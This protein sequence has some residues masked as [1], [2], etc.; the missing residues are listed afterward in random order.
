MCGIFGI[1]GCE[2]VY[3]ELIY[4]LTTLQHRG[5][6]A[7]GIVTLDHTFNVKKG[8]GLIN[9]VFCD[10]NAD[11]LKGNVGLGHIRY[12]TKGS[13]DLVDAQPF[14]VNYPFGLA[15]VHNGNVTNFENL[16]HS[17]AKKHHR[18]LSSTNDVELILDILGL[19]LEKRNLNDLS[20][21]D[22]FSS[23]EAIQRKVKGAYATISIIAEHGM[24]AF[25]DPS[26]IRPLIF[27]KKESSAGISYAFASE[28]TCLD[29]LGYDALHN[30]QPGEAMYIDK[31]KKIHSKIC[32]QKDLAFC[33]FEYIYFAKEDSVIRGRLVAS[34]RERMG[35][36]LARKFREKGLYPDVVI[37]VPSAAYFCAQGLADALGVPYKRGLVKN[38][39]TKRSFISPTKKLRETIVSRKLNPI[40]S[41]IHGKSVAVVDDSI[42]RGTTSKYIIRQLRNFGAKEI[43]FASASPPLKHPCIYGI[44]MSRRDEMIASKKSEEEIRL[45]IEADALIYPTVEDFRKLYKGE[46]FCDACFSSDYPTEVSEKVFYSIEKE[47]LL[48]CR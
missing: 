45:F 14:T 10:G 2:D 26:A 17:L 31:E 25:M 27:G 47:K 6:D 38:N 37:D 28:S 36:A 44:D 11:K 18:M 13:T 30:L 24:L 33:I 9:D 39:N 40:K 41:H 5:Q 32:F 1:V 19:E 23:V 12:S 46:K 21:D 7:S 8:V 43:Y 42:V 22:I 3:D 20:V 15:M 35:Y 34:E 29:R 4:G 16:N 48:T